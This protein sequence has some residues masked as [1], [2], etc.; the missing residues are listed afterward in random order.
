MRTHTFKRDY[1]QLIGLLPHRDGWFWYGSLIVVLLLLPQYVPSYMLG[2]ATS[3]LIA[4]V[5]AIGLNL[6]I[7]TAGLISLGQAG[8]LA[9]GAYGCGILLADYGWPLPLAILAAGLISAAFS[10]LIGIPSLRLK[11]LY[12]A[13][14]TLAFSIIVTHMIT[15]LSW[16]TGGSSGK[17]VPRP[18]LLGFSMRGSASVYYL[19]LTVLF[20]TIIAV[21]NVLRSRVGRAW[22]AIRDYDVAAELMGVNVRVYKLLAFAVSSFFVGISGALLA[23]NIRYLNIESFTLITTIEAV[24]MII[25]GG[26]GSVRGAVLGAVVVVLLPDLGRTLVQAISEVVGVDQTGNL[27]ELKGVIYALIIMVFLR[28]EPDGLNARW[29]SIKKFWSDWPFNRRAG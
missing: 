14:T 23:I 6:V 25:V 20:F 2:Y 8:F 24:A 10:V 22:G 15:D 28:Y 19:S 12:L 5:G 1:G 27:V 3:I 21:L 7:G 26:L 18:E 4:A 29:L 17:A 9:I 16:L 13:I 11:G